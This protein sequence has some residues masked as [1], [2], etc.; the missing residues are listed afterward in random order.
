[1]PNWVNGLLLLPGWPNMNDG[2][3]SRIANAR[4]LKHDS[5]HLFAIVFSI[6]C[7]KKKKKWCLTCC[8]TYLYAVLFLC[9]EV[10]RLQL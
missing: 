3:S 10:G 7:E 6:V 1:M 4:L 5:M 2:K 8:V 9:W